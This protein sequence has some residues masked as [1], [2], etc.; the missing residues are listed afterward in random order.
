M[1]AARSINAA[2]F[3]TAAAALFA[4]SFAFLER[5]LAFS[6]ERCWMSNAH[7][8]LVIPFGR[9]LA[10]DVCAALFFLGAGLVARAFGADVRGSTYYL[11]FM[12][13]W[14]RKVMACM[15]EMTGAEGEGERGDM[16][17]IM[18]GKLIIFLKLGMS[19]RHSWPALSFS[20]ICRP[21]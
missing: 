20:A 2:Y 19:R 8:M 5:R 13:G 14:R 4:F 15:V 3:A 10:L 12:V 11:V 21:Q 9:S 17:P 18:G 1:A 7:L 16:A 6:T